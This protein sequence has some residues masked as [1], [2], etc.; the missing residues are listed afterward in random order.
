MPLPPLNE[1]KRMVDMVDKLMK[2]CDE[3]ELRIDK[4]KKCNERL[5]ES[6]FQNS[7]KA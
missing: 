1:Q 4:S 5:M 2:I 6:I 7:L 3:L